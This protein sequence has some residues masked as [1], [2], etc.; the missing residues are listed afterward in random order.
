MNTVQCP[1]CGKENKNTNIRCEFCNKELNN[2]NSDPIYNEQ[3]K[4]IMQNNARKLITRIPLI[5]L[6]PFILGLLFIIGLK[7]YINMSDANKTKNYLKTEGKL[8]DYKNCYYDKGSE[9]CTAE[10]DH[11]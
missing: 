5:V 7:I 11:E 4:N 6:S 8:I 10:Y 2:I 3:Q 1:N 9:L